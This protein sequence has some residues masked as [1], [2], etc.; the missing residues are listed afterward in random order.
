MIS[1]KISLFLLSLSSGA[2][3][4]FL[5]GAL[6]HVLFFAIGNFMIKKMD[7]LTHNSIIFQLGL[8]LNH[9]PDHY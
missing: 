4:N 9:P 1:S 5:L 2:N 7:E 8:G 3:K 6:E